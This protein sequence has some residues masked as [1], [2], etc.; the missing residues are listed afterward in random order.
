MYGQVTIT[1][2]QQAPLSRFIMHDGY[3]WHLST[4]HYTRFFICDPKRL[5][6]CFHSDFFSDDA[7]SSIYISA[8]TSQTSGRDTSSQEV[9]ENLQRQRHLQSGRLLDVQSYNYTSDDM[10]A[11]FLSNLNN[12]DAAAAAAKQSSPGVTPSIYPTNHQYVR[13]MTNKEP[14]VDSDDMTLRVKH[15]SPNNAI[16]RS[17]GGGGDQNSS[18]DSKR[19]SYARVPLMHRR[20]LGDP[21]IFF[22][23]YQPYYHQ[24]LHPQYVQQFYQVHLAN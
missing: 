8:R 3:R 12:H 5:F 22:H 13:T 9:V 14:S 19:L 21:P 16:R 10:T 17:G 18:S 7:D 15:L 6:I 24:L 23:Q 1:Y 4:F 11:K 20:S 2:I